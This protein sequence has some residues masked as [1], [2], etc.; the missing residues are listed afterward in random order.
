VVSY[1][2]MGSIMVLR[3]SWD[4][5]MGQGAWRQQGAAN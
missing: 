2:K 4:S 5:G 1:R 3:S